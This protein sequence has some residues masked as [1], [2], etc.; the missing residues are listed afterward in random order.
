MGA[1]RDG[2]L[3]SSAGRHNTSSQTVLGPWFSYDFNLARQ[4][5]TQDFA[6]LHLVIAQW[7]Q[8]RQ[9]M[10]GGNVPPGRVPPALWLQAVIFTKDSLPEAWS[11]NAYLYHSIGNTMQTMPQMPIGMVRE[12]PTGFSNPHPAAQGITL[13]TWPEGIS[14]R[15]VEIQGNFGTWA[16]QEAENRYAQAMMHDGV[17]SLL[18]L[19]QAH[20][21]VHDPVL[22]SMDPFMRFK[23][24]AVHRPFQHGSHIPRFEQYLSQ[25]INEP[26]GRFPILPLQQSSEAQLQHFQLAVS[27][28]HDQDKS[29]TDP[30]IRPPRMV[31]MAEHMYEGDI[32]YTAWGI[33]GSSRHNTFQK[34]L[35]NAPPVMTILQED[36]STTI[37]RLRHDLSIS[38][39]HNADWSLKPSATLEESV[40]SST[41]SHE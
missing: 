2:Y 15:N 10:W 24:E 22:Y 36:E 1:V 14:W 30:Q 25:M 26:K 9:N 39:Q 8:V 40:S 19:P 11:R 5:L 3:R 20:L 23:F 38:W 4:W 31:T 33:W 27:L 28:P 41:T 16:R 12:Y 34:A 29:L 7:T 35:A 13:D 32:I 37:A 6:I 17:E 21:L 18:T